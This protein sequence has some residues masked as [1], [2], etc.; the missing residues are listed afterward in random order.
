MHENECPPEDLVIALQRLLRLAGT[1]E[2][3]AIDAFH[4]LSD[5]YPHRD[6]EAA[7]TA[8]TVEYFGAETAA[9]YARA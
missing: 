6:V 5:Q 1:D 9:M 4:V 7:L 2:K 3:A 8:V